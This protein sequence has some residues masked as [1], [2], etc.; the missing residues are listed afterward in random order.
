LRRVGAAAV[1]VEGGE[2][3]GAAAGGGGQAFPLGVASINVTGV[4]IDLL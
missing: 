1:E 3:G 2:S 4:L